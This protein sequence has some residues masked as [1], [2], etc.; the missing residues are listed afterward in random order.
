M[1]FL[2]EWYCNWPVGEMVYDNN[3]TTAATRA[4]TPAI[5][6]A[7]PNNDRRYNN[8][9]NNDNDDDDVNLYIRFL[10]ETEILLNVKIT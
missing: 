2:T 8:H 7:P 5:V 10:I 3:T 6:T 4:A 9:T 1:E